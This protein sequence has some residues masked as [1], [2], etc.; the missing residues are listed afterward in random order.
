MAINTLIR[1]DQEESA[2]NTP[3]L[4]QETLI[5]VVL[6][7][8]SEYNPPELEGLRIDYKKGNVRKMVK[9][10]HSLATEM[11]LIKNGKSKVNI[12][13]GTNRITYRPRDISPVRLFSKPNRYSELLRAITNP[14]ISS[15]KTR[16][17][18]VGHHVSRQR[19]LDFS[20]RIYDTEL[21]QKGIQVLICV[22]DELQLHNLR[23]SK[24]AFA[25]LIEDMQKPDRFRQFIHEMYLANN[26]GSADY[27]ARYSN[28]RLNITDR[29]IAI[30]WLILQT[31]C[32]YITTVKPSDKRNKGII[33]RDLL[34]DALL[35]SGRDGSSINNIQLL[36]NFS[37]HSNII[38]GKSHSTEQEFIDEEEEIISALYKA[39]CISVDA[40][41]EVRRN[42]GVFVKVMEEIRYNHK[43]L[44]LDLFIDALKVL[45]RKDL[46]CRNQQW[47]PHEVFAKDDG[48]DISSDAVPW[49]VGQERLF[50]IINAML[51]EQRRLQNEFRSPDAIDQYQGI[52]HQILT[53]P[54]LRLTQCTTTTK[55]PLDSEEKVTEECFSLLF[56]IEATVQ[57]Q[58]G[59]IDYIPVLTVYKPLI[60]AIRLAEIERQKLESSRKNPEIE[61]KYIIE[62][63]LVNADDLFPEWLLK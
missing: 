53:L 44:T 54:G 17:N 33:I 35:D 39:Y 46:L 52:Q 29:E 9:A 48:W 60:P 6:P 36:R 4:E 37:D 25:H 40:I 45:R 20:E 42:F 12:P 14:L 56:T 58:R 22:L 38:K 23:I 31:R 47:L 1:E 10:L 11:V 41:P 63:R 59:G 27:P 3:P 62:E 49:G 21:A 30:Q 28:G 43:I 16:Q 51:S 55:I 8:N 5:S 61:V 18:N 2:I 13:D 19:E 32:D 24:A 26:G 34:I 15:G 57:N 7:S 50:P